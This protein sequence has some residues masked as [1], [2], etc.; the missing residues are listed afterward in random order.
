MHDWTLLSILIDWIAGTATITF[1]NEK[2]EEVRLVAEG[3]LDIHVP[4]RE[5][6]GRSVSI[7]DV[8]GPQCDSDGN[9]SVELEVQS[10]D[11]IKLVARS[12]SMP[13]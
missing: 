13:S 2:S 11:L 9:I 4:K 12:V 6:W 10:G 3:I 5:E 8:I 1:R 7:N